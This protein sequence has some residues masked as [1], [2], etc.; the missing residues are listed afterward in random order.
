MTKHTP[1]PW[2]ISAT[3]NCPKAHQEETHLMVAD[4]RNALLDKEEQ[5]KNARLIAAAPEMLEA[6]NL[7]IDLIRKGSPKT[8][9]MILDEVAAKTK[10][11]TE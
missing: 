1:G 4:C 2:I 11:E 8:A 3:R 7:A 6:I 9:M 5:N 10:G